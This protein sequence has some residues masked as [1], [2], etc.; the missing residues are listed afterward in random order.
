VASAT[1]ATNYSQFPDGRFTEPEDRLQRA[2]TLIL[3]DPYFNERFGSGCSR[4]SFLQMLANGGTD[5]LFR[6]L[7]Q[8]LRGSPRRTKLSDLE[9][10]N[11]STAMGLLEQ[12]RLPD[13]SEGEKLRKEIQEWRD[14]VRA[15]LKKCEDEA[16]VATFSHALRRLFDVAYRDLK[17]IP[18]QLGDRRP[19]VIALHVGEQFECW[20][21]SRTRLARQPEGRQWLDL[22]T[23]RDERALLRV[24][25][26]F[27][28]AADQ[29]AV[30]H[31]L[32]DHFGALVAL[33]DRLEARRFL[34]IRMANALLAGLPMCAEG[35]LSPEQTVELL[36]DGWDVVDFHPDRSPHATCFITP[37]LDRLEALTQARFYFARQPQPGDGEL[38][39]LLERHSVPR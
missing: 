29:D 20:R 1:L 28:Q 38:R 2:R 30:G 14:C 18:E 19:Q 3:E 24:L 37:L 13:T 17:A 8:Q 16:G 7:T 10:R 12:V 27:V 5:Y 4:E 23:L 21:M 32:Q 31:W 33:G 39:S 6:Q 15:K 11:A 25:S 36:R 34:A 26:A 9:A 35:H 22:V